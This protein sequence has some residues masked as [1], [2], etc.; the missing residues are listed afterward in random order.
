MQLDFFVCA[1]CHKVT[2]KRILVM[3]AGCECGGKRMS[4]TYL[5]TFKLFWWVI[6]HLDYLKRALRGEE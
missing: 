5:N 3:N 1:A 2:E 4:P 6:R